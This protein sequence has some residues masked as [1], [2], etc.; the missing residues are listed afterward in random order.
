MIRK[1]ICLV[2][3]LLV[4]ALTYRWVVTDATVH[5]KPHAYDTIVHSLNQP[6]FRG[7]NLI[8][9]VQDPEQYQKLQIQDEQIPEL[10]AILESFA[11]E[12]KRLW[13]DW[14]VRNP[15][16]KFFRPFAAEGTRE[17]VVETA[18][19]LSIVLSTSQQQQLQKL[20]LQSLS[21]NGLFLEDVQQELALRPDQLRQLKDLM[22]EQIEIN[23]ELS[24][25]LRQADSDPTPHRAKFER[26]QSELNSRKRAI[27]TDEQYRRW[28]SLQGN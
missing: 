11:T 17:L 26:D 27:L 3:L 12:S 4:T 13:D 23:K 24:R 20:E 19:E 16:A 1:T 9:L 21:W 2:A 25:G 14:R 10:E 6:E 22:I 5:T 18:N 15:D 8:Q 7:T 28:Q